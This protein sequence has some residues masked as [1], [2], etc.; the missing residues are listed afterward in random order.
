MKDSPCPAQDVPSA[1]NGCCG[2]CG[3]PKSGDEPSLNELL[4]KQIVGLEKTAEATNGLTNIVG[5]LVYQNA[6]LI[7]MLTGGAKDDGD[8]P[9]KYMDGTPIYPKGSKDN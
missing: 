3:S 5:A 2:Q 6:I 7:E 9:T 1:A 4:A 8:E